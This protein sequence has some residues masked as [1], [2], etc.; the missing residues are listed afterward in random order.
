MT[1][2]STINPSSRQDLAGIFWMLGAGLSFVAV[3]GSVRW[4]G[5]ALPA[6]EG[7]FIRFAFG[8]IFLIPALLPALRRGF[9]PR[10]WGMFALRGALHSVAV[11]LWFFAMARITVAEVTAIGFLNPIVV[12][13]GAALLMGERISWRRALAILVALIGAMVV[14]RPGLRALEP[15]HLAQLGA[16]V[17][18]G[19]SYLL[20]KRLSEQVPASVV[21]GMMSLTV[22]IGLAPVAALNWVPPTVTQCGVLACTA[23]FATAG[24]YAM[25]RAFAAAPLTVTQPVV[26]LQ[27]I[28]ASLLGALVFAEPVDIWVLI[29]GALMI[30]A[31]CYITWRE[32]RLRRGMV[33]PPPE[34]A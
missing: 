25:T 27:L 20:A 8:L 2:A 17:T 30:G 34:T 33:T 3:N 5:Q 14:L 15:G 26:F 32:A 18:F 10:I 1:S 21:V 23:F 6:P 19:A 9:A 4:L 29:G 16:S 24:H 31:I 28:W 7:A 22:C 11:I 13:I 12:T